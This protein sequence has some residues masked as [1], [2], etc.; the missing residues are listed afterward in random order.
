MKYPRFT[1]KQVQTYSRFDPRN[2]GLFC[3]FPPATRTQEFPEFSPCNIHWKCQNNL[4]FYK[5]DVLYILQLDL[6]KQKCPLYTRVSGA[7]CWV[8]QSPW[9]GGTPGYGQF[10][11]GSWAEEGQMGD[12]SGP[13]SEVTGI[14]RLLETE[15]V[16]PDFCKSAAASW[17]RLIEMTGPDATQRA[18]TGTA[19]ACRSTDTDFLWVFE[20]FKPDSAKTEP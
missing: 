7:V 16:M 2:A 20:V 10:G 15:K 3:G 17:V 5:Y 4:I 18:G 14:K 12:S 6:K 8:R 1:C 19:F 13:V 9:G 11:R